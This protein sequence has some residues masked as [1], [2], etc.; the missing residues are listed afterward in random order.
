MGTVTAADLRTLLH[1]AADHAAAH[2]EA[3]VD[4]PVRAPRTPAEMV[5]AFAG[6]LPDQPTEA[7]AVLDELVA[8][9]SP[10]ITRT[11]S[12]R[13]FGFVVGGSLPAALAADWMTAAWDNNAGLS[14]PTPAV[15]AAEQV[16]GEWLKDILGLPATASFA[17]V[18]GCQ[19]AHVTALAAARHVVLARIGWDAERDGLVGAP[20]VRVLAGAERHVTIDR[21][22]RLLGLGTARLEPIAVDARGAMRPDALAA[23]L[24]DGADG[25]AI[26]CAQAG[27]VNT[28]AVDPLAPIIDLVHAH[29]AWAHVDGAFGL[30]AAAAPARRALLDGVE[31]ADSW[32][33]DAHKWLNVPYDCGIA[34]VAHP[35]AHRAAMTAT[36]AY[37]VQHAGGPREPVDWTPEFS[38][39]ARGLA[40][41]A[42]L[43]S[44]GRA[45]VA[46]LVE[47]TCACA[48]RFAL[49]LDGEAGVEVLAQGLNQVLVRATAGDRATDALVAALQEDG[50]CY[51]TPTTW[52]GGRC[53]RIS[54]SNWQTT[55]DD[56]DR[57]LAAIRAGLAR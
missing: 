1:A 52:R 44:L 45:G 28:G 51:P 34:V 11:T 2:L 41:W 22:L 46:E 17:L 16:A 37:L 13:F 47:R 18:T 29:G 55:A 7:A 26:V 31:R 35:D 12:A 21:A 39:R 30:W 40:V 54:V 4:A 23:A 5:E 50:T 9:A 49:A 57:S 27:N 24:R 43:R 20:P 25:P 14:E 42:A 48:E 38:R 36:A 6:P 56:V 33:T 32:A 10:G 19:M 3:D 15:A 8:V 53:M